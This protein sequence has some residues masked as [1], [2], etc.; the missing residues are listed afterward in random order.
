MK[1]KVSILIILFAFGI[2]SLNAQPTELSADNGVIKVMLDL[3]RGGAIKYLS[4]S[5]IGASP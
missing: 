4:I 5:G 1:N 3:T 2:L